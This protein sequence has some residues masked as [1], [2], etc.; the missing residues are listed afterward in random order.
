M[1]EFD[2]KKPDRKESVQRF[3]RM[4]KSDEQ[5]FFDLDTYEL[6]VEHYIEIANWKLAL[7][8]CK[9]GLDSYPYSLELMLDKA[10]I[11]A[12]NQ[13]FVEAI[14]LVERAALFNPNDIDVMYVEGSIYNLMGES[15]K[16]I[17]V[18]EKMLYYADKDDQDEIYFQIGQSY[19]NAADYPESIRYY[20]KAI[21]LNINNENALYELAFCLDITNELES[22][23]DYY[24]ELIDRDPYSHNAWYNLGIVYSK[25]AKFEDAIF[26]Y[27]YAIVIKEDFA[28]AHFNMANAYMNLGQFQK[29]NESY[30]LTIYYE[31]PT[32][33]LYCHL[34]ASYE[35]LGQLQQALKY[36]K[37]AVK[38]DESWDEGWYGI[39][40]C[41]TAESRFIE[42][43]SCVRK[44][45]KI[46][47]FE[48]DY[49]LMLGQLEYKIG[50]VFSA[51][52]AFAKAAEIEPDYEEVWLQWSLLYFEEKDYKKAYEL[53]QDGLDSTPEEANLYYRGTA[54]LLYLGDY[55]EAMLN[56]EI[57]LTLDYESHTQLFD[58]FPE[59]EK[60]KII[61]KLIEQY[62]K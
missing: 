62:R 51:D 31:P 10:H 53:V 55:R 47:E 56:L 48:V 18:Y 54:Y 17:K 45:L 2:E 14:D 22:S 5:P 36:F 28:S 44:A 26:A 24:N 35:K 57:A 43:I 50:N 20:K 39:A 61:Y 42:A 60:Q 19:Q 29:A 37:D 11:L 49:W 58:F 40:A 16:A 23:I 33:D 4:L 30:L 38:L 9:M 34:G 12:H 41:L 6:I 3:E 27:D 8:A 46:N 32:A 13:R 15:S 25:L 21:E 52:E 7:K 59:I 1:Q